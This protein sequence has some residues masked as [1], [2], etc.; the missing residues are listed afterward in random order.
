M[1]LWT[2]CWTL[3]VF[4]IRRLRAL[5]C[6]WLFLHTYIHTSPA[7]AG[8]SGILVVWGIEIYGTFE[9]KRLPASVGPSLGGRV[10]FVTPMHPLYNTRPHSLLQAIFWHTCP[11]LDLGPWYC[12]PHLTHIALSGSITSRVRVSAHSDLRLSFIPTLIGLRAFDL[13]SSP[14]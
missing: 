13:V 11:D 1:T 14:V 4:A 7:F 5:Y 2:R 12:L 3:F 6:I 8:R 9:A 10:A